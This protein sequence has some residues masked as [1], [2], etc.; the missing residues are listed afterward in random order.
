MEIARKELLLKVA[1]RQVANR[2]CPSGE[3]QLPARLANAQGGQRAPESM[4]PLERMDFFLEQH[5]GEYREYVVEVDP[6][7]R[8]MRWDSYDADMSLTPASEEVRYKVEL[9]DRIVAR[10]G[11][12]A[13][14]AATPLALV[15]IPHPIDLCGHPLGEVDRAKYPDYDPRAMTN[16]FERIAL[17]H[18]IAYV[19]LFTPFQERCA[20]DLFLH[21]LDD[22]W[23][24]R[25]QDFGA[26]RVAAFLASSG[27]L[28]EAAQRFAQRR[29]SQPD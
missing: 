2:L 14:Q 7:V 21:G 23:N 27:L 20:D 15:L 26:E 22:H 19:N 13:Q 25:G 3:A 8:E 18:G 16:A 1:L 4:T 10:I 5:R 11:R 17:R 29:E 28:D 9:M 24:D 12:I 6:I